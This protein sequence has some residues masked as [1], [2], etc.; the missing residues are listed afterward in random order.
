MADV[1]IFNKRI[2]S[3]IKLAKNN[4]KFTLLPFLDE[5][6]EGILL[7]ELK[8]EK[9]EYSAFGGIIDA[10]RK[11]YYIGDMCDDFN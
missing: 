2:S 10:E 4:D 11:R 8:K 7:S 9:V 3:L 1:E 6:S 5:A